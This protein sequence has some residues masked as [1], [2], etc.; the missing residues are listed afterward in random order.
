MDTIALRFAEN[1]APACGTI[2]AHKEVIA[3]KGY[4]WYGKLGNAISSAVASQIL[5][6]SD[7]KVLLIH[8]GASDRFWAHI[9]DIR[10]EQ[11]DEEAIPSYYRDREENFGSWLK[12]HRF[13]RAASDIMSHCVVKSSGKPLSL[14]S[15]H[16]MSPYFIIEYEEAAQ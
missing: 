9:S 15:R 13:E 12:V 3:E 6:N 8:S 4:V 2:A 14:A 5:A 7:P 1:F 11:I 10:R 16:S